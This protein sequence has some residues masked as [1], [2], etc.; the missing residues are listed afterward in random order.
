MQTADSATDSGVCAVFCCGFLL[1]DDILIQQELDELASDH[2]D[3]FS[4]Y[5]VLNS[6]PDNWNGGA[7]FITK[8]M[9]QQHLPAPTADV[10][11]LSCGPKAMCDAMKGYLDQL[12]YAENSQFQ[13]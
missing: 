2:P 9:I 11:V 7:G 5:Y 10:M 6:P 3:R 1:A 4:V 12:G 13:F 8:D